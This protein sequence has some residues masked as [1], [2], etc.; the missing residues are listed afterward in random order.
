[1]MVGDSLVGDIKTAVDPERGSKTN[2]QQGLFSLT[3]YLFFVSLEFV[4][5]FFFRNR[6]FVY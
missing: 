3:M 4:Q 5:P 6:S 1:M 2:T